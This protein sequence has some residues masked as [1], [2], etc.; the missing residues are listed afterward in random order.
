M[1]YLV[2]ATFLLFSLA[3]CRER[4][5]IPLEDS[6]A[7]L[8]VVEGNILN[9]DTT[10]I[11]L[12]RTSPISE[13]NLIVESGASLQ[14]EGEDNSVYPLSESEPGFYKSDF[15][16]LNN[17]FR[18]RL[19]IMSGSKVYESEWLKVISTP[20]IDS[21]IWKRDNGVE[22]SVS[23]HGTA[24]DT[25][26]YKWDYDEVW[27]F[28]ADYRSTGYFTYVL[29]ANG[30]KRFQCIDVTRE[31]ITYNSC[32]EAYC[33][34]DGYCW[35]DSLY[36]CW[37]YISSSNINIGSTAAFSDNTILAPVR[38]I[39]EDAWE[40]NYLYSILVKQTGLTREGYE[41]YKILK[42][43]SEGLGTIFDA[44]PSQMKTNL[45]CVTNPDETVI[46]FLD[47]TI[48]KSKRIFI[49]IQQLPDWR[50]YDQFT[51]IDTLDNSDIP[52]DKAI[53]AGMIPVT[54]SADRNPPHQ[55]TN[56]TMTERYCADC[57]MRGVHRK[58][59]FWP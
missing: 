8:L 29:D 27:E 9:G 17:A 41:F 12:S 42:G 53:D 21:V 39:D 46:G 22:I 34:P 16:T 38:K 45:K 43:N 23:S 36:T 33:P 7:N 44:Q 50:Y 32:I 31:G 13:R 5:G 37:K 51:C 47:A 26:Y 54:V 3:A 15:L 14:I 28:H 52:I 11:R 49:H 40:L 4:Y 30:V 25:R 6:K 59:D 2:I 56:F 57:T 18:Y 58:P 1:R 24:D 55:I 10:K 48:V 35:N 19:K 20:E